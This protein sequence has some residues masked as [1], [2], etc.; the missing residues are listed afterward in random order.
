VLQEYD[1]IFVPNTRIDQ[2]IININNWVWGLL[3][4]GGNQATSAITTGV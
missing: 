2:T 3:P 4:I 1:V